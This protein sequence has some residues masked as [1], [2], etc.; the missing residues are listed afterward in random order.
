MMKRE[1]S[2]S[3]WI[4]SRIREFNPACISVRL[5]NGKSMLSL[6]VFPVIC[7]IRISG[8]PVAVIG[9]IDPDVVFHGD[10]KDKIEIKIGKLASGRIHPLSHARRKL[11]EPLVK[12]VGEVEIERVQIEAALPELVHI[13]HHKGIGEILKEV[14]GILAVLRGIAVGIQIQL[15]IDRVHGKGELP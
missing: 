10:G 7:T 2:R 1:L 13:P 8:I 12:V 4:L 6:V 14:P 11:E 9:K 3:G 5:M 15:F